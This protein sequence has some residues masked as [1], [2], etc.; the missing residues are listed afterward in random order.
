MR[1]S[2]IALM[3]GIWFMTVFLANGLMHGIDSSFLAEMQWMQS[4]GLTHQIIGNN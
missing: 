4:V 1:K 3:M 2:F